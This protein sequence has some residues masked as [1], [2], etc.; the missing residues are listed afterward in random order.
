MNQKGYRMD[1]IKLPSGNFINLALARCIEIE[2]TPS[3]LAV[4]H[5]TNNHRS[6]YSDR[7]F[8]A[9]LEAVSNTAV[10]FSNRYQ[11]LFRYSQILRQSLNCW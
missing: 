4:V 7:D 1:F 6:V 5:W 2:H 3:K 8:D 9:L 10:D 11:Q